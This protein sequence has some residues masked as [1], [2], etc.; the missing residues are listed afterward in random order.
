MSQRCFSTTG[1]E[2]KLIEKPLKGEEEKKLIQ[3]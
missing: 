1:P 3:A 2:A